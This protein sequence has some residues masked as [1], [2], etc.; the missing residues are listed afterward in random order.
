MA[1]YLVGADLSGTKLALALTDTDC[2]VVADAV[3]EID[4]RAG[5]PAIARTLAGQVLALTADLPREA[6]LGVG[7]ACAGLVEQGTGLV[8]F[9]PALG[10]H[11]VP[12]LAMLASELPWPLWIDNDTN[13]AALAEHQ[14]GAG[15]GCQH[16]LA[17][18][19]GSGIGAG[20]I[21]GGELYE[22]ARGFAGE[23]GHTTV[24][25]GDGHSGCLEANASASAISRRAIDALARG[26]PSR[27]ADLLGTSTPAE[28]HYVSVKAIAQAASEGDALARGIV[29]E[30]AE[31][32]G[33]ALANAAN[34]LNPERIVLGGGVVRELPELLD[35]TRKV[36]S[37]LVL[38]AVGER[39]EVVQ[40]IHGRE[41]PAIGGA[42]MVKLAG[43]LRQPAR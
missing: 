3:H 39:L 12:L 37:R 22:G 1:F 26:G 16:M 7:I 21:L 24:A 42:V 25:W 9:A 13:L 4:P 36:I 32:L 5:A 41:G 11:D 2:Q 15:Q 40:A 28:L 14:Q 29:D 43:R 35:G 6:V 31:I 33:A 30:T 23:F 34:F 27:L 10:W 20:L 18:F 19:V 17:V 38:P 8:R